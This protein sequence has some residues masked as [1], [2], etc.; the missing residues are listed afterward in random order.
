MI[1]TDKKIHLVGCGPG[2]REYLPLIAFDIVSR[3]EVVIGPQKLTNLF[4]SMS[5]LVLSVNQDINLILKCI[6]RYAGDY[7]IAV[8]VSGDPGCFSLSTLII[9]RFGLDKC[10]VIPGISSVQLGFSRLGLAWINAR[11]LS[12]HGRK[13]IPLVSTIFESSPCVILLGNDL[14]WLRPVLRNRP[15]NWTIFLMQD[16]GLPA[17]QIS[18]IDTELDLEQDISA[19]SLL[20]I[21]CTEEK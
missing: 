17:E 7:N 8:L 20:I 21:V 2:S 16:L 1:R 18:I 5:G 19:R 3:A 10:R 12:V 13:T 14:T 11:V 9:N 15:A 6:A 4:D